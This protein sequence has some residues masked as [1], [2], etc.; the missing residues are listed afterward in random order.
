VLV[1]FDLD[2]T[3]VDSRLDLANS[4]NDVLATY[5]AP[6]LPVDRVGGLVGEGAR[7]LVERALT[8]AGLTHVDLDEALAR[9]RAVY[10]RRLL[11]TTRPYDGIAE[12][13]RDA[14]R[15]ASLALFTNKPEGPSRRLLEA[16]GLAGAFGW[17]IG[18]DSGFPRKPDP[19][20]VEHLRRAAAA[21]ADETLFVGDSMIDVETARRAGVRMCVARYGFGHLR[22]DL[23]LRG[24]EMVADTPAGVSAAIAR[25][26]IAL[27]PP[28]RRGA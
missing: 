22:G 4:T 25:L 21:P 28:P 17:V 2:G 1:I 8:A 7:K 27:V 11:E 18:G 5:G 20:A 15:H 10:D 24:D 6:P 16:F 9:F 3:L 19:A 14:A 23:T 12:A 26:S 13:V